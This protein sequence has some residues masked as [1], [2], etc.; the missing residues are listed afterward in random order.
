M[1]LTSLP[2]RSGSK[3]L[4]P[5]VVGLLAMALS[6]SALSCAKTHLVL[7]TP[8]EAA[9]AVYKDDVLTRSDPLLEDGPSIDL[10]SPRDG[11]TYGGPFPI[12][13]RFAIGP[14]GASVD[15]STIKMIYRRAWGID[16]TDRI[17]EYIRGNVVHVDSVDLPEGK[18][19]VEIFISDVKENVSS[20][21]FTVTVDK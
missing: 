1:A 15:M 12:D 4:T 6:T 20:R 19:R 14:S 10:R 13:L 18:H 11:A 21:L 7:I 3:R 8:E 9:E 16:I 2:A 17:R 5:T